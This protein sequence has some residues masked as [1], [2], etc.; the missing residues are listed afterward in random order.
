MFTAALFIK[1][2]NSSL[3][4]KWMGDLGDSVSWAS[5]FS[6][7]HDLKVHE[8]EPRVGLCADSSEPGACFRFCVSLSVCPS[9]LIF[10]LSLCLSLSLSLS[11]KN[12][13]LG[14]LGGS[15][16]G[17]SN[18]ASGHDLTVRE[19]EP[20]IRLCADSPEPEACFRFCV[21]LSLCSLPARSLSLSLSLSIS[22]K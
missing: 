4:G 7:G 1:T 15:I 14:R 11:L 5:D 3:T 18:F 9:P 17:A 22:Q 13:H 6:L 8:F 10:S 19:F 12:K 20:H 21:S 2:S 16:H